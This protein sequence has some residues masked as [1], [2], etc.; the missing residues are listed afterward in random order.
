MGRIGRERLYPHRQI[1]RYIEEPTAKSVERLTQEQIREE[2]IFLG[3]R[4]VAGF[5]ETILTP[6]MAQRCG[7]LREEKKL[8]Y[9]KG[10]YYNSDYLLSDEIALFILG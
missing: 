1:E 7:V 6:T 10:R 4:S 9:R 5:D 3:L 2:K 8:F